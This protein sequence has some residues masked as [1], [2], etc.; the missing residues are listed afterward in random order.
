MPTAEQ[1]DDDC[2]HNFPEVDRGDG[3]RTFAP[4]SKRPSPSEND[5][6]YDEKLLNEEEGA[7]GGRRAGRSQ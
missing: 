5:N 1:H 2:Y 6:G 4:V 7:Q 3:R